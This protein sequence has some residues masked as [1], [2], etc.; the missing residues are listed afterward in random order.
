MLDI[1]V[2][3]VRETAISFELEPPAPSEFRDRIR[4]VLC[5]A[6]WLVA[7][8]DDGAIAGY[9]YASRFRQRPAYRWTVEVTIFVAERARGQGVGRLLYGR[10]LGALELQGFRTAVAVIALPNPAS[11]ALHERLGF[12]PAGVLRAVGYK[13]GRWHDVGLWQRELAAVAGHRPPLAV[14][15]VRD[16]AAWR[17]LFAD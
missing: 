7:V 14:E 9:T 8:G 2:P 15:G 6:P 11:V 12:A 4:Q 17:A 16:T 5:W 13:L 1:Y 3:I 10:L